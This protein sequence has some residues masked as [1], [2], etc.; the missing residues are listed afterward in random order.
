MNFRTY[1]KTYEDDLI[2]EFDV[3]KYEHLG[4]LFHYDDVDWFDEDYFIEYCEEQFD[5]YLEN[6][7]K[8]FLKGEYR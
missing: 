8:Q 1:L 4:H 7:S 3:Y 2:R 5:V 6:K